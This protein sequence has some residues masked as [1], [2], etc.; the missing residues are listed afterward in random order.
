MPCRHR[1]ISQPT[2]A[3]AATA[4]S[5]PEPRWASDSPGRASMPGTAP[6]L[7][8]MPGFWQPLCRALQ[9]EDTALFLRIGRLHR[10]ARLPVAVPALRVF[11]VIAW[12]K[13]KEKD[14]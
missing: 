8:L 11:V 7:A 10:E 5:F 2:T 6:G 3:C 13:G 1:T 14:Y 12:M 9:E 4:E